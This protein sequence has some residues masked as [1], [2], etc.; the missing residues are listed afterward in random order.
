MSAL[1]FVDRLKRHV[2]GE[3]FV[4][5][6]P[7]YYERA[8]RLLD[9]LEKASFEGRRAWTREQLV[10]T[11]TAARY[12]EYGR[13]TGAGVEIGSWPLLGK[14]LLRDRL[15]MFTTGSEWFAAVANTGGTAGVPL[16]LVRSL[17]GIVF[18]QACIDRLIQGLDV[19][20]R[21][22]RTA[23]VRGDNLQDPRT[24]HSP[25]GVSANAGRSRIFC[26]HAVSPQNIE[27]IAASLD[28]FKPQLLCAYPSALETL[29]RLLV[30]R[31]HPLSIAA[32]LTSS[33]VLKPEG[34]ALAQ[35]V[36]GARI[37]DYY[38]QS[39]RIA[40]AYAYAPRE[41]RFLPG[42]SYVEFIPH[43]GLLPEGSPDRLYE[44]V[45][46]SFWNS[47]MPLVRYR[48]GDLV[49]L[50][51]SWGAVELEELSLGLRSFPGILGREQEV[52][53]CPSG[54]RL[55]GLDSI[56]DEVEH[57]LRIQIVQETLDS[58]RI[59][60]VPSEAF[61][62]EDSAR[63]LANVRSKL[64]GDVKLGIEVAQWLERT[65]RGKTPLIIHRPPVYEA[66]KRAGIEPHRTQ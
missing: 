13:S 50:P 46:T 20:P 37:C 5:R 60:V 19:S 64:P 14:E 53:V 21:G 1:A 56:P 33:E 16:K 24:L 10:R 25:D 26:A 47:L 34:W 41:Y 35:K 43:V 45:G 44:I 49:R 17:D 42:Y 3:S 4:R 11:L 2:V 29:C 65:P 36:L 51:A 7:F 40:L 9:R 62:D 15:A 59:R 66:L 63:L 55:T 18:E 6:N 31:R 58:A 28:H 39:E 8:R 30:E 22:V 48:T 54:V 57:V 52:M 61:N 12:A 27:R 23:I 38:G 32:V